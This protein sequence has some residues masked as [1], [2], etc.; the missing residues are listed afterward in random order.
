MACSHSPRTSVSLW[1][2]CI[3]RRD[4][5]PRSSQSRKDTGQMG[6]NHVEQGGATRDAIRA[7]GIGKTARELTSKEDTST[8]RRTS[9]KGQRRKCLQGVWG[10]TQT[11][12]YAACVESKGG[13]K[14]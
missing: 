1:E 2:S 8:A 6:R 11:C 5:V 12:W 7:E 9:A 13:R 4:P 3:K 14:R 10:P